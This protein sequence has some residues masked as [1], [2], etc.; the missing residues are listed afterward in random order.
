MSPRVFGWASEEPAPQF[1]KM[2]RQFWELGNDG[3]PGRFVRAL[4]QANVEL[5]GLFGK[6]S[7]AYFDWPAHL[8]KCRTP[9]QI[10]DEH[11]RFF[12][13]MLNDYQAANGRVMNCWKEALSSQQ[14]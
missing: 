2:L 1:E 11:A 6:R 14:R 8:A 9:Q 3:A 13:E 12:E 5:M 10:L 7:R 4:T